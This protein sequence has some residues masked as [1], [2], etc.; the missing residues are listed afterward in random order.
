M[1]QARNWT[2]EEDDYLEEMWGTV[3]VPGI[4]AKLN[5]TR[6]AIKERSSKKGLGRFLESGEYITLNQLAAALY[7]NDYNGGYAYISCGENRGLPIHT[8]LRDKQRVRVVYLSEFW[9]WAEKNRSYLDFSRMEPLAL[10]KEPPWVAEQRAKDATAFPLQQKRPWTSADDDLLKIMLKKHRYTRQ[11]ISERLHR[12]EGAI[13]RRCTDLGLK[14]RPLRASTV[15][16]RPWDDEMLQAL[17]DGIRAGDSY[18]AIGRRLGKSE[19]AVRGK[20]YTVYLTENADAVRAMMGAGPWGGGAPVPT[21]KQA[22][23]IPKH[24]ATVKRELSALA[25]VI[26]NL[27]LQQKVLAMGWEKFWQRQMCQHW[28]DTK[29]CSAGC[30][31]CD[32]CTEFLRI[33]PQF[34]SRCGRDFFE[35]AQNRFCPECRAARKKQAQRR[36]CRENH[37]A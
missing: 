24:A 3:S 34:C 19:K 22:I 7:G 31:D 35:R 13:Q 23:Y 4:A 12:S 11:E 29:G 16:S 17:A 2:R 37:R 20:V 5:R 32:S 33:K 30:S 10:G 18:A 8:K 9:K 28:S 27:V 6:G 21:V 15:P 36:W 1:G 14:E 26:Q 25:S